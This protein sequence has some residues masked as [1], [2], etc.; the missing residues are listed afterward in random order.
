MSA[1]WTQQLRDL[2]QRLPVPNPYQ[3]WQELKEDCALSLELFGTFMVWVSRG[4]AVAQG[5]GDAD[6][7]EVYM[8]PYRFWS[9]TDLRRQ[10]VITSGGEAK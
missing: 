5:D 2:E 1:F 3:T 9:R 4:D 8:L 6:A 7:E 10:E